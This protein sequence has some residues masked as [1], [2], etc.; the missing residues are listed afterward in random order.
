MPVGHF[1]VVLYADAA[2]RFD[3]DDYLA[4]PD[5]PSAEGAANLLFRTDYVDEELASPV[6]RS[7]WAEIYGPASSVDAALDAL[8]QVGFSF[9]PMIALAANAHVGNFEPHIAFDATPGHK[10]R[11][12]FQSFVPAARGLP[13]AGRRVWVEGTGRL[14]QAFSASPHRAR[15]D[16]ATGQYAIALSYW[17]P[18]VE[19][20]ALAHLYM[21]MEALTPVVV[22]REAQS[23]RVS[24]ETMAQQL[25]FDDGFQLGAHIRKTVLFAGEDDLY[26]TA[27]RASDAFEHGFED[28]DVIRRNAAAARDR[29]AYLLRRAIIEASDLDPSTVGR[30]LEPPYD[31]PKE[32]FGYKRYVR[33][34]LLA[35]QDELAAPDKQYPMLVIRQT[36]KKF[37]RKPD[38]RYELELDTNLQALLAE[39]V[40]L[41]PGSIEMWG[42]KPD[43]GAN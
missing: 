18:N 4:L 30:L 20:L 5:V 13:W 11:E 32:W 23:Q 33:G 27:R 28:F 16:R 21:G 37:E 43:P 10:E 3:P 36:I 22:R 39:G 38:G 8:G 35:D 19:T 15:L 9:G 26:R 2:A 1:V 25:G 24:E 42:P 31:S 29:T 40:R 12:F 6:P 14:I 34:T 17:R 41:Q 7:M